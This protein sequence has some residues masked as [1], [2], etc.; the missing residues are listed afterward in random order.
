MEGEPNYRH[1]NKS[2]HTHLG[3]LPDFGN[4]CVACYA[5]DLEAAERERDE[6]LHALHHHTLCN[7]HKE[8][9]AERDEAQRANL[10]LNRLLGEAREALRELWGI[11]STR[12]IN[13]L[14]EWEQFYPDTVEK[15]RRALEGGG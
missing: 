7:A 3:S 10:T 14:N 9:I 1:L 8:A 6:V 2:N 5:R 13:R 15:V 11:T 12:E 4:G